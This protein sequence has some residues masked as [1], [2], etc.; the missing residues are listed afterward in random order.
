MVVPVERTSALLRGQYGIVEFHS[1]AKGISRH[2]VGEEHESQ[3]KLSTHPLESGSEIGDHASRQPARVTLRGWVTSASETAWIELIAMQDRKELLT[4]VTQL[5]VYRRMLITK[6]YANLNERTGLNMPFEARLEEMLFGDAVAPDT[7]A[8]A[9]IDLGV[10][11]TE[12]A[13][14]VTGGLEFPVSSS[15][16]IVDG[17]YVPRRF[18]VEQRQSGLDALRTAAFDAG[19][20][21]TVR[22]VGAVSVGV[23][24][25]VIGTIN[26]WSDLGVADPLGPLAY[27]A[28]V[29]EVAEPVQVK[30][31]T[32][33]FGFD[34]PPGER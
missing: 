24:Y 28:P 18:F 29:G 15:V 34:L 2:V 26:G 17:V 12:D 3:L 10:V 31:A 14:F 16:E 30:F 11:S 5:G 27:D 9:A 13:G 8:T 23:P 33:A 4:V 1:G 21:R 19:A 32:S 25:E 7:I 20:P 6:A 22:Q